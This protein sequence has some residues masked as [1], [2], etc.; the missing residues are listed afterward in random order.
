MLT[1]RNS[2]ETSKLF[3]QKVFIGFLGIVLTAC[4]GSGGGDSAPAATSVV[5]QGVVTAK[6]SVFVNG[7]E[8]STSGAVIRVDD[9]PGIARR[10]EVMSIPTMIVFSDGQPAKRIVGAKG[11]GQMLQELAEFL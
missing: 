1:H 11:K 5:S 9:N 3:I 2:T 7:I 4:G 8:Y 10:F 6:G